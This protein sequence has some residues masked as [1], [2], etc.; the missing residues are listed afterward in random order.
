MSVESVPFGE[1]EITTDT[2]I[3]SYILL[4]ILRASEGSQISLSLSANGVEEIE[5]LLRLSFDDIDELEYYAPGSRKAS[6]ILK[7]HRIRL[8][9]FLLWSQK[10][11]TENENIALSD[12]QWRSYTHDTFKVF[13][14]TPDVTVSAPVTMGN[15]P[16]RRIGDESRPSSTGSTAVANFKKGIK[17]DHTVYPLLKEQKHWNNWNRSVIAQGRAH[18]IGDIFNPEFV[19]A[20]EEE[21][22]LFDAKQSFAYSMLNRAVMTDVGKSIV[23]EH[24]HDYDAQ[25]VYS[26][27]LKHAKLSTTAELSCDQL[28]G[29]LTTAKLDSRWRGTNEGFILHWKDQLRQLEDMR[30]KEQ[31][32]NDGLKR[33]MLEAAVTNVDSLRNVKTIDNIRTASGDAPM[34]YENYATTLLSAAVQLD[35]VRGVTSTRSKTVVSSHEFVSNREEDWFDRGYVDAGHS[36]YMSYEPPEDHLPLSINKFQ[37]SK[38]NGNNSERTYTSPRI[39]S[40]IWRKLPKESQDILRGIDPTSSASPT[41]DTLHQRSVNTHAIQSSSGVGHRHD[42]DLGTSSP[43][44]VFF[45]ATT[46]DTHGESTALLAHV[47]NRQSLPQS[48][49]RRVLAASSQRS[50]PSSGTPVKIPQSIHGDQRDTDSITVNGTRYLRADTHRIKY[51]IRHGDVV[52]EKI[53]SLV[54]RGANG[55]MAGSDVRVVEFSDRSVDICGINDHT[56]SNLRVATVAGVAQSHLGPVCLIMHQYA[57]HGK[58]KTIHSSI[59]IEHFGN[60]VNDKSI[61]VTGGKQRIITLDGYAIPLNLRGGL[62]YLDMHPPDDLEYDTLPHVIITSDVDWE[63]SALD[64]EL[65]LD[66]FVDA[67]EDLPSPLDYGDNRF[68]HQGFYRLRQ[69]AHSLAFF[70]AYDDFAHLHAD[71]HCLYQHVVRDVPPDFDAL[72]PQ[73][74]WIPSDVIKRTFDVTTRWARNVERLPFRKH[75]K[76]RFPALNVHRRREAVATDTVYSDTPAVDSGAT[77]A[78]IFVGTESLVTDVYGMRTD[79]EFVNTLEDNIRKRGAMSQLVSDRAQVEIG[80][81]VKDILRHFVIGDY[82]SEPYHE[83]QNPAER[84]YQTIKTHTNMVLDRSGAPAST[85]LLALMYVCYLLN[86]TA[87]EGLG[88][89]TPLFKLTGNTTDISAIL[90]FH[91]WEPIYFAIDDALDYNSKPGFPSQTSEGKGRFVGIAESVGDALTYKI[92][93]DDT[94]KI[95]YRSYVRSALTAS[96]KNLRLDPEKGDKSIMEV[97]KTPNRNVNGEFSGP[98]MYIFEPD[99]LIN[100]TYLTD[101][102][103]RGQ[104]FR[105]K[106]VQK[107]IETGKTLQDHPDNVKFL[108][109]IEGQENYD[110][111]V[112]YNDILDH[113]EEQMTEEKLWL[114]KDIIAH[115]GPLKPGDPSYKGSSY[116]VM[117]AWEDGSQTFEPLH[118]IAADAPVVCAQYAQRAGLLEEPGWKRFQKIAK[119]EKKMLRQIKQAKLTS[120]RSAPIY[121]FGYRVPRSVPEAFV[122]DADNGNTRWQDAMALEISQLKEYNTFKD[123]GRGAIPPRDYQKIRVHFVFAVKHDGRHKARLVAGGHLTAVPADSV[124]SGVVS[125]R[126]LRIIIFVAEL[127]GLEIFG[128]DVGN[129]YLEAETKE[130]V[131]I[132][133]SAGFGLLEGHTLIIHKALYGLRTSGLRWHERLADTL[134]DMGFTPSKADPDVWIRRNQDLYEYIGVYVDD[135]AICA[136]DPKSICDILMEK[137]KF[138]LKGVGP[139]SH[140]LGCDYERDPDGTLYYGPKQYIEKMIGAYERMF[141]EKPR[142]FSSP[143]EKN[144]HPELDNSI[145]LG[146]EDTTKYQSMIGALQ[147]VTTLGRFDVL[148]A[149][150]TMSRF[151]ALPRIG[152]LTRLKRI[153]GYLQ[154]FPHG[155]IRVRVGEPDYSELPDKDYDWMYTVYGNVSEHVPDDIP[156]PL[157]NRVVLTTYVDAN[158]YHDMVTGRAV[159]GILHLLNGTPIEWYSKRQGTV[160]VATYGSEFVAARI[161]TDQIIDIRNTLRY[162]GIPVHGR[163]YMFGDN[164]SVVTSST[165]PHSLLNKRHNAL[166]YHRVREAIAAKILSFLH[167]DGKTNPADILS[168]HCAF[169]QLWP[170]VKPLLFWRGDTGIISDDVKTKRDSTDALADTNRDRGECQE[171]NKVEAQSCSIPNQGYGDHVVLNLQHEWQLNET[172]SSLPKS[173]STHSLDHSQASQWVRLDC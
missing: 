6:P 92:L 67:H 20:S 167:I 91:F 120:F 37:Q 159:T 2:S 76:S 95:I 139:L 57:Y 78:Q 108:V 42:S 162:L 126:S 83:H 109:T 104:R 43:D 49:I 51:F 80:N 114:F 13:C 169:P 25:A 79:K 131:Y 24:E 99:E 54:D 102:D 16:V 4:E 73:F 97:V 47:T 154:K 15:A 164:E 115:E 155:A 44:D 53:S 145:E 170:H 52:S 134:R 146:P 144:D 38:P 40:E 9:S 90:Q 87:V 130:R 71:T 152:H 10:L 94:Q 156:V 166:S 106:I 171:S 138:K 50:P 98:S 110:E 119:R 101:P 11:F 22:Q 28:L 121:M 46:D 157:G 96:E 75:F 163:T 105:A 117:I 107:I 70:D 17:L 1:I 135:L 61:K 150:M 60:E 27:L 58:G 36:Y 113:L 21:K 7:G 133:A 45:D 173:H 168:K 29:Y 143:L 72:R 93:T 137:Y 65:D 56:L 129:A 30:P 12:E 149:V 123:L 132:V 35:D 88:W 31:R 128:C 124:Y 8:K 55:G 153:Y 84:R 74:G 41:S 147:W 23:R 5:E 122:I 118:V 151:R 142:N 34:S 33:R 160:E 66:E 64:C 112:A 14:R 136:R 161:A 172:S 39:P 26:K 125:L 68:D 48:D 111:I 140:H 148:T 127:N 82:Q 32:M 63:P 18:D 3:F 62:A 89:Q 77:S 69:Q 85:W 81:R 100:R 116:N 158:L 59:Q 86:H 103:E 165:L 19:P 141:G